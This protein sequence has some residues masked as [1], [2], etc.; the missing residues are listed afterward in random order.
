MILSEPGAPAPE[1]PMLTPDEVPI[2]NIIPHRVYALLSLHVYGNPSA[3]VPPA[4]WKVLL[5]AADV[6]LDKEGYFASAYVN[7]ELHH[8][9][10]SQRGTTNVYTLRSGV[11][12]YFNEHTIA[13]DLARQFSNQVRLRLSVDRNGVTPYHVSYTGHSFGAVLAMCRAVEE[14]TLAITF[15]SPGCRDFIKRTMRPHDVED[16]CIITYLREPN[17]INTLRV[18][19]GYVVQIPTNVKGAATTPPRGPSVS[20][21]RF[22][23]I[24]NPQEFMRGQIQRAAGIPDIQ[25]YI[26]RFEP[27]IREMMEQTQQVHSM[28]EIY[29][30][31]KNNEGSADEKLVLRW[32]ENLLQFVEYYN[33]K[34]ALENLQDE[35]ENCAAAY[36]SLI[37]YFY[38]VEERP[39]N[40]LPLRV[41]SK[42]SQTLLKLWW[43]AED[44]RRQLKAPFTE[45]DC[46]VLNTITIDRDYLH[47]SVLTGLQAAQYISLLVSRPDVQQELNKSC[48]CAIAGNKS[49]L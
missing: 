7:E 39:R 43:E 41:L 10:V 36:E 33:A 11:W 18:H 35:R 9:I 26:G 27:H 46:K 45:I 40:S 48:M 38:R 25:H 13:F 31:F 21:L 44:P 20:R 47:S 29:N 3:P 8:C 42:E 15:E 23:P 14:R 19:C 12:S 5:T 6:N 32:P 49:R 2:L 37:A 30:Y 28:G 34:K 4:P 22:P 16:G 24:P 1:R 17:P